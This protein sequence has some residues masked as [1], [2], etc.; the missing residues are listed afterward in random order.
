MANYFLLFAYQ[1]IHNEVC[2]GSHG[3]KKKLNYRETKTY[4]LNCIVL[5]KTCRNVFHKINV[6]IVSSSL[7]KAWYGSG[8]YFKRY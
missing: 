1:N 4:I 5:Q 7:L 6:E 8:K 2:F 3:N